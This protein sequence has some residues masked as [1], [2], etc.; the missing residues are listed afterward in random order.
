[1]PHLKKKTGT[2]HYVLNKHLSLR[3]VV[4]QKYVLY[5]MLINHVLTYASESLPLKRKD[6][7]S[8]EIPKEI[9]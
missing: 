1:M 8:P 9:L 3:Y 7:N 4:R 5:D 6:G 2:S